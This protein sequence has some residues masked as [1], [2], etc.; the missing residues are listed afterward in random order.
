MPVSPSADVWIGTVVG[1]GVGVLILEE[2]TGG[3]YQRNSFFCYAYLK[4]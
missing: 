3:T 1:F 4:D 2:G